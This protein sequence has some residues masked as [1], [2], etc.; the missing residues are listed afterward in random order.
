MPRILGNPDPVTFEEIES[1]KDSDLKFENVEN[2]TESLG[3]DRMSVSMNLDK[4]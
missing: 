3:E 1:A 4:V 2:M